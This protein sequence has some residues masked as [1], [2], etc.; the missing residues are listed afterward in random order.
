VYRALIDL[1]TMEDDP[2]LAAAFKALYDDKLARLVADMNRRQSD[3]PNVIGWVDD[4]F[5]QVM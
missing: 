4:G 5:D 1:Y 3:R 2:E